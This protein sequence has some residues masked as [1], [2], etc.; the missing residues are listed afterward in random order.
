M[1]GMSMSTEVENYQRL[2]QL[3]NGIAVMPDLTS[4]LNQNPYDI[5]QEIA[6]LS[7]SQHPEKNSLSNDYL[8]T[9]CHIEDENSP[10]CTFKKYGLQDNSAFRT[11]MKNIFWR[12]VPN[13]NGEAANYG[14]KDI[15]F[16]DENNEQFGDYSGDVFHVYFL[17]N[18]Y[19]LN[20]EL[21]SKINDEANI[22]ICLSNN[23]VNPLKKALESNQLNSGVMMPFFEVN[24]QHYNMQNLENVIIHKLANLEPFWADDFEFQ[25]NDDV[26]KDDKKF[27]SDV[28]V[29]FTEA[30]INNFACINQDYF[31]KLGK[32]MKRQSKSSKKVRNIKEVNYLTNIN[33]RENESKT[34]KDCKICRDNR[35]TFSKFLHQS[36]YSLKSTQEYPNNI[37]SDL[38]DVDYYSKGNRQALYG[39]FTTEMYE[40]ELKKRFGCEPIPT[41][42]ELRIWHQENPIGR[43]LGL[44]SM[45]DFYNKFIELGL[46]SECSVCSEPID[47]KVNLWRFVH[48]YDTFDAFDGKKN[49]K[50]IPF[51]DL[52][53]I[54]FW[55]DNSSHK[56]QQKLNERIIENNKFRIECSVSELVVTDYGG[57]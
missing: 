4:D 32:N 45:E 30:L 44:R 34:T 54:L 33:K 52:D 22:V 43:E 11:A 5:H 35:K 28:P 26:V 3:M 48:E 12:E 21:M 55:Q 18:N 38:F 16:L 51:L 15:L 24:N 17:C 39:I 37:A 20:E 36:V 46:Y 19:P 31:V 42:Y 23:Y 2:E 1:C 56:T 10:Y 29:H 40:N 57:F 41:E 7:N 8:L 25:P 50:I 6:G 47:S 13:P 14:P 49:D 9:M 27:D 53:D